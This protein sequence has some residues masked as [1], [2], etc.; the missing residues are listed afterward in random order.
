MKQYIYALLI[1]NKSP[2]GSPVKNFEM[3]FANTI[4][5]L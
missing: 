4:L 1:L 3:H 2:L 5:L